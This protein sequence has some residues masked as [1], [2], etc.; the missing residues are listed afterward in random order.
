MVKGLEE[1]LFIMTKE[2]ENLED[3]L[4][5]VRASVSLNEKKCIFIGV[6]VHILE[7]SSLFILHLTYK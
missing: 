7:F 3:E 1:Q 2:K 4:Q 6:P 5:S